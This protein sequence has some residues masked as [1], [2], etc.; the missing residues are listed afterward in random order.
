MSILISGTYKL[1]KV[2]F[3]KQGFNLEEIEDPMF[4]ADMKKQT[5]IPFTKEIYSDIICGKLKM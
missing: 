1:T 3:Q 2:N 4:I 5:Y